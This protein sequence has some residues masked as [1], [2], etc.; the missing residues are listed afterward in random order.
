MT[1]KINNLT[2]ADWQRFKKIR[3]LSLQNSPDAFGSTYVEVVS[4]PDSSWIA[5]ISEL[6]TFIGSINGVDLG[7]I[8]L[9]VDQDNPSDCWLLLMWVGPQARGRGLGDKLVVALV[10]WAKNND[11][12]RVLLDVGDYNTHA[13]GLYT[14]NGFKPS[15]VTGNLP[16]PRDDVKELQMELVLSSL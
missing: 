7:V 4:R 12:K 6:P 15:G 11:F 2:T 1:I 9:A 3:L 14:R 8:R 13:I 16:A 10:E 5:Q